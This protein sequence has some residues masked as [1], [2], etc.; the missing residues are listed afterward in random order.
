MSDIYRSA[1]CVHV[2]LGEDESDRRRRNLG[3][4]IWRATF[5]EFVQVER[6]DIPSCELFDAGYWGAIAALF[7]RTYWSRIWIVQEYLLAVDLTLYCGSHTI[8]GSDFQEI[9]GI[10]ERT[11]MFRKMGILEDRLSAWAKSCLTRVGN[12]PGL[13]ISRYR[14]SWGRGSFGQ[15]TLIR[16]LEIS[17]NS[18]SSDS[19]DRVYAILGLAIDVPSDTIQIDY[20]RS[21]FKLKMDVV[22]LYHT[23]LGASREMVSETCQL[24]DEIFADCVEEDD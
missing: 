12:S 8:S 11:I 1:A 20:N 14:S 9:V 4:R 22:W 6:P 18:K 5:L 13:K 2:W 15:R 24:L 19:H 16:L 10:M 21:I 17:R 7:E 23:K 3:P